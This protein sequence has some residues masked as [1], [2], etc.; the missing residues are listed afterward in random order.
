AAGVPGRTPATLLP[1]SLNIPQNLTG[2]NDSTGREGLLTVHHLPFTTFPT[3]H[4]VL[5]RRPIPH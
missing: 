3:S 2:S 1:A 4:P 5:A